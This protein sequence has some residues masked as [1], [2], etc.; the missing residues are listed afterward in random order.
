MTEYITEAIVIDKET[1]GEADTRVFFYTE[2]LGLIG[3]NAKSAR[4]VTSKLAS[5]L[6][7]LNL[8]LVRLI[9]KNN[10]QIADALKI[11]AFP[12]TKSVVTLFQFI[13]AF[14]VH[15]EPDPVLWSLF[16][17]S[18]E[19]EKSI[20]TES[21]LRILGF[22]P[23]LAQCHTCDGNSPRYFSTAGYFVCHNCL[24]RNQIN[25]L[26]LDAVATIGV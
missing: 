17:E 23:A 25:G 14:F 6:E 24:P 1:R 7:P 15:S 20:V 10:F 26:L 3:A 11:S 22:D 2:R 19:S 16:K 13:K 18:I 8:V 21:M 5:H 4:K 12:K 9:E